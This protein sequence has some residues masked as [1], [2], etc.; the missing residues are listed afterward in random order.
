VRVPLRVLFYYC[1]FVRFSGQVDPRSAFTLHKHY[2]GG[3]TISLLL[4]GDFT[5]IEKHP[6][7]GAV[8]AIAGPLKRYQLMQWRTVNMTP[9]SLF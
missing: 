2:R 9:D 1:P 7:K 6:P 5:G 3:E 8:R 4:A